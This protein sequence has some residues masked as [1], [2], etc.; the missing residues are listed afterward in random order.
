MLQR[1]EQRLTGLSGYEQVRRLHITLEP[2]SVDNGLLTATLK[3]KRRV[4]EARFKDGI[5]AFY[6]GH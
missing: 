6:T 4:I 1:I 5:E 2:W 3:L